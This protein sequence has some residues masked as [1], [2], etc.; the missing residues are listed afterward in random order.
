MPAKTYIFVE[1]VAVLPIDKP[2]PDEWFPVLLAAELQ[3]ELL[4][5]DEA[6]D[7]QTSLNVLRDAAYINELRRLQNNPARIGYIKQPK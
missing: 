7:Y 6:D 1:A 5:L 2:V 4:I 3:R